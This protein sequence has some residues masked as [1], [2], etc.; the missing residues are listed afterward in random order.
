MYQTTQQL[1]MCKNLLQ[2]MQAKHNLHSTKASFKAQ[3]MNEDKEIMISQ[4]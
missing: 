2:H 3:H 1:S 4:C